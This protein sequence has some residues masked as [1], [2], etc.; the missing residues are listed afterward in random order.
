MSKSRPKIIAIIPAAG[1]G[2]RLGGKTRKQ[3]LPLRGKPVIVHTIQQFESCSD[4]DEI[5][6][7]VPESAIVEM[8]SI[9]SRFRLHKVG[10]VVVGGA[11]RQDSVYNILKTI[12][13]RDSDILLVH[14]AVRPFVRPKMISHLV[15]VC[16]EHG[17]A[18]LAVQPKDTVRRSVGGVQFDHTIDRSALWLVQTPQVFRAKLLIRA[19]E[20]ARKDRFS[21]TDDVAL[22]ERLGIKSRIVEGTYDN[23]KIT[24]PDDLELGELILERWEKASAN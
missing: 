11:R 16:R 22:V 5:D 12:A 7:A 2:L 3:F 4:V 8:E 23:I 15:R 24:T 1:S 13:A 17:T 18:V 14:D 10:K 20:R 9:I 6:I 21:S 19:H